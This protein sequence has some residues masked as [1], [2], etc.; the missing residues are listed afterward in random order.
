MLKL[1]LLNPLALAG[2]VLCA[3]FFPSCKKQE[4][5]G[6]K[7]ADKPAVDLTNW[8]PDPNLPKPELSAKVEIVKEP[9]RKKVSMKVTATEANGLTVHEV[10]FEIK[11]RVF[12]DQ[13]K[14][15]DY[16]EHMLAYKMIPK[17][18]KGIGVF[19]TPFVERELRDLAWNGEDDNWEVQIRGYNQYYKE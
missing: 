19:Q 3:L 7:P 15:Y 1:K 2:F 18:E 14:Q 4:S 10:H 12:N 5:V 6:T 9:E 11:Y 13:T 8:K 16:P 17:V